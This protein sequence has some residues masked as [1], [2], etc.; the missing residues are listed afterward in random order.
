MGVG[1]PHPAPEGGSRPQGTVAARGSLSGVGRGNVVTPG[2]AVERA[3]GATDSLR[4]GSWPPISTPH[5]ARGA[6]LRRPCP[7]AR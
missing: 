6:P 7:R 5:A 3:A 2:D 4:P 1:A